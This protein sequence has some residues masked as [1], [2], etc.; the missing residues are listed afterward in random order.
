MASP[1]SDVHGDERLNLGGLAFRL[2]FR[3]RL[4]SIGDTT[5]SRRAQAA[6]IRWQ[7]VHAVNNVFGRAELERDTACCK[8]LG[9]VESLD[10]C[11]L[12]AERRGGVTSITWHKRSGNG[13][14]WAGACYGIVDGTWQPVSVEP[15]QAEADSARVTGGQPQASP[16]VLTT[17]W[18]SD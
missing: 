2:R 5:H 17:S 4:G 12:A 18:I 9:A 7:V 15:G 6:R 1:L 10:R 8:Y 3:P 16:P 14:A 13:G 11:T